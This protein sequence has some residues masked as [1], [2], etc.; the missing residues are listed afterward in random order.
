M[1]QTNPHLFK[2][3]AL[4]QNREQVT[5]WVK[6]VFYHLHV[7]SDWFSNIFPQ[8]ICIFCSLS[9]PQLWEKETKRRFSKITVPEKPLVVL[10]KSSCSSKNRSRPMNL[11][12]TKVLKLT[13]IWWFQ[14]KNGKRK[15]SLVP[16]SSGLL[17]SNSG[18]IGTPLKMTQFF[19][20]ACSFIF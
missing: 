2:C 6:C 4:L 20:A 8:K 18:Q 9:N 16:A 14:Y 7:I 15:L 10:H 13:Q 19:M 3:D 5:F 17:L 12:M 11:I 1:S